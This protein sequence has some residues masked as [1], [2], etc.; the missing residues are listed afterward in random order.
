MANN[1]FPSNTIIDPAEAFLA[2]VASE[3][4]LPPPGDEFKTV[5]LHTISHELRSPFSVIQSSAEILV[6]LQ[7]HLTSP[8]RHLIAGHAQHILKEIST[9]TGLI[10]RMVLFSRWELGDVP[11]LAEL[12]D[13][14]AATLD[15]IA[16]SFSPWK[17]GRNVAL[18]VT[19]KP[20]LVRMDPVLYQL[21]LKNLL[22]K[23]ACKYSEGKRPPEIRLRFQASGWSVWKCKGLWHR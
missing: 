7:Q 10:N 9:V 4:R 8:E 19:G 22:E 5:L 11:P 18:K 17:D 13:I 23:L 15:T 3:S 2:E 16:A 6:L 12:A 14:Q 1:L 20:R 21:I